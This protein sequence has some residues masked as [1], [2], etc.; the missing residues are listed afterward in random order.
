MSIRALALAC[1]LTPAVAV[2][3]DP[4]DDELDSEGRRRHFV[5]TSLFMAFN[6]LFDPS[7]SFY[8]LNAGWRVTPRDSVSVEAITW[9]YQAPL[10]IPWGQDYGDD[11][12]DF[13]GSVRDVGV[14]AAYQRFWWKGLYSQ[15]HLLPMA[16]TYQDEDGERIQTGFFLFTTLRAGY[17]IGLWRDRVFV[18]PSIACTWWPIETNVPAGFAAAAEPW[19]RYFLAEPGLHA[20]VSF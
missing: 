20:G 8:Q 13:P 14:G 2:G 17:H 10:G 4:N 19:P 15:V 1:L 18:E 7:P 6:P 16:H 12:L 11:A 3:A 9:K 5:G